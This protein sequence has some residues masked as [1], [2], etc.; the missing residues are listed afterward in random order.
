MPKTDAVLEII[1]DAMARI[2]DD[3]HGEVER[4]EDVMAA[5]EARGW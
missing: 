2:L 5:P 3:L 4:V 1:A